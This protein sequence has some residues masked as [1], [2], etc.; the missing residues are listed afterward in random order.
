VVTEQTDDA[1]LRNPVF[2]T[3]KVAHGN[4]SGTDSQGLGDALVT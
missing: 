4:A 1:A 3:V 2:V